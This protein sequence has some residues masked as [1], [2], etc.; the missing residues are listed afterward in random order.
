MMFALRASDVAFG[1][2]VYFVNDVAPYGAMGK[3][4]IICD[5]RE[6]HHDERSESH[7]FCAGK[8]II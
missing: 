5:H 6:Q 3:H 2:D 7:H 8:N 4:R 1:N